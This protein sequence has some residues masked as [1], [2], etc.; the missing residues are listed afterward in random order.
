MKHICAVVA[1]RL[2]TTGLLIS[3]IVQMAG[4]QSAPNA[5]QNSKC[6]PSGS[7]LVAARISHDGAYISVSNVRSLTK[8]F[9]TRTLRPILAGK[10]G[11]DK[12]EMHFPTPDEPLRYSASAKDLSD[13]TYP[14]QRFQVKDL[15]GTVVSEYETKGVEQHSFD[16]G[17]GVMIVSENRKVYLM[18]PG[19]KV[20]RIAKDED[21]W[22]INSSPVFSPDHKYWV[23]V[24]GDVVDVEKGKVMRDVFKGTTSKDQIIIFNSSSTEFTTGIHGVGLV[25]YS[26]MTGKE[27]RRIPI[28]ADLPR[29]DGFEVLPAPN[30]REFLYWLN[31]YSMAASGGLAYWVKDGKG[32][33]LC[34][35]LWEKEQS[36]NFSELLNA[37][38][39]RRDEEEAARKEAARNAPASNIYGGIQHSE[40]DM[41]QFQNGSNSSG[42]S[43]TTKPAPEQRMVTCGKCYGKGSTT[44]TGT[45]YSQVSPGVYQTHSSGYATQVSP[46]RSVG[47]TVT[48]T[49]KCPVCGGSGKVPA[50]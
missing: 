20:T 26:L 46:S 27:L 5:V 40:A 8:V 21:T 30:G 39:K 43:N 32:T 42:T 28:P 44:M 15:L 48:T 12:I 9:D 35:P 10:T 7:S 47:T 22:R 6:F 17:S 34:D 23:S 29:V 45:S 18:R 41:S 24:V 14:P 13:A 36:D 4:A 49:L 33:S 19:K 31:F 38:V 3:G 37:A 25:T 2:L 1:C 50:R 11:A 16:R